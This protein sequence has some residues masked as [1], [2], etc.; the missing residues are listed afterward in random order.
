M[1]LLLSTKTEDKHKSLQVVSTIQ[2]LPL[3]LTL[4]MMLPPHEKGGVLLR[5]EGTGN[6]KWG[7]RFRTDSNH[8]SSIGT[9]R[10]H[11]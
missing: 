4:G 3:A 8:C 5:C 11:S 10:Q 1:Y 2:S 6:P 7:V 9:Q